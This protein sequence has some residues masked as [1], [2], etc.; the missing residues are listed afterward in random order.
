MLRVERDPTLRSTA[1]AILPAPPLK[2]LLQLMLS[3]SL[4]LSRTGGDRLLLPAVNWRA[5]GAK[6]PPCGG[7]RGP[8]RVCYSGLPMTLP[9]LADFGF[10]C[11]RRNSPGS[12]RYGAPILVDA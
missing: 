7:L 11:R 1:R 5:V 9:G 12:C 8:Y 4:H 6:N 10:P 3:Y 2:F